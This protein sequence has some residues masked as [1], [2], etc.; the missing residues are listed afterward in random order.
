MNGAVVGPANDREREW[1]RGRGERLRGGAGQGDGGGRVVADDVGVTALALA[2][3]EASAGIAGA[4][5]GFIVVLGWLDCAG[6]L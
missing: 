3:L 5:E 2:V 4:L 1:A 6:G